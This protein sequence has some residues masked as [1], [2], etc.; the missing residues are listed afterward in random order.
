MSFSQRNQTHEAFEGEVASWIAS[1]GFLIAEATYHAVMP[2]KVADVVRRRETA[3]ARYLRHRADR[4]AVHPT[5]PIEFEWEAKTHG[6]AAGHNMAIDAEQWVQFAMHASLG[7]R[8]LLCYQDA[9]ADLDRGFW[10][11]N[12]PP[13]NR[14]LLP[15]RWQGDIRL[16]MKQAIIRWIGVEPTDCGPIGGSND[17][18]IIVDEAVIRALPDWRALIGALL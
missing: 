10:F 11:H 18:L 3:T 16:Q 14:V 5:L 2:L 7:V 6:S 8:C 17:P 13:V 12:L 9:S 4:I 1:R 15:D